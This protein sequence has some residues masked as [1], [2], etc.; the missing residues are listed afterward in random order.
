[1]SQRTWGGSERRQSPVFTIVTPVFNGMPW[2]PEAIESVLSQGETSV[3]L[4]VLDGGST[5]GSREWLL[6]NVKDMARLVFEPDRGQTDALIRGLSQASGA[7]LGW[8]PL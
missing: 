1:M 4:I 6:S 3:E 2:L 8:R 7:Y 5:D